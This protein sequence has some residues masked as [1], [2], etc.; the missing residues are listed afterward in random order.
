M[1]D[2]ATRTCIPCAGAMAPM[3]L[4]AAAQALA[5]SPGWTFAADGRALT[6]QWEFKGFARA[7]QMANLAAWLGKT[8]GCA[9]A[10]VTAR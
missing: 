6:R 9:L 4:S 5:G 1:S 7:V 3:D 2:L 10:G 8:Q